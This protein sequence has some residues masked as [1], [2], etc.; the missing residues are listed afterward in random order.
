VNKTAQKT[1]K[2]Y[3][4]GG[5][6]MDV[7]EGKDFVKKIVYIINELKFAL[8]ISN[9]TLK[10]LSFK[11]TYEN[12]GPT[13]IKQLSEI[14]KQIK[15]RFEMADYPILEPKNKVEIQYRIR[16]KTARMVGGLP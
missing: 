16:R 14:Q 13:T 1:K 15:D 4:N 5:K 6:T 12:L 10:E 7:E 9:V 11:E 2:G 8:N 3:F